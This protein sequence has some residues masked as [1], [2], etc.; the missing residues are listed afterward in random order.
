MA[1]SNIK[2]E[3]VFSDFVEEYGGVVLDRLAD[4]PKGLNADYIFHDG[5]VVAELKILK[6][7]PY[8][9]KDF[10]KSLDKKKREWVRKG[11]ISVS[12][13]N[14]V[15]RLGQLPEQCYRDA[16]KLYIRPLIT[17]VEKANRQ[18]KSTKKEFN[19]V[20]YKGLLI[21]VSD[22]NFLLDPKNIRKALGNL[23]ASGRYSAI[24]TVSYL[25]INVLTTRPSDPTQSRLWTN[26]FRNADNMD[27]EVPIW[28]LD[29]LFD[30]WATHL[31]DVTGIHLNK[32][33]EVN[34]KGLSEVDHLEQTRFIRP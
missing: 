21:L 22:G 29:S 10:L 24:N 9:N 11:Y 18:I 5:G 28:F 12:A 33:S 23:F 1:F 16:E 25:T 15:T 26:L 32:I 20:D 7:D 30:K 31:S 14:A 3:E 13:L 2:V 6:D 17:H 34:E 27:G 8:R 19:L 4:R